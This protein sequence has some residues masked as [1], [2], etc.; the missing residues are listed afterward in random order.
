MYVIGTAGHV[1]H[2]KSTLIQAL[3]GIDPDRLPQEKERGMTIDLGFAWL[4]LPSGREVSIVDVPGHERFVK[5]MLAGVGGIDVALLVV[6]ADEGVMPQTREHLAILDLLR[7]KKGLVVITK[8][9]LVDEEMLELVSAD[10][11][12]VLQGTSFEGAPSLVV[13]AVNGRG[14]EELKASLDKMLDATEPRRDLG[15]PRLPIDR[16]F[17]VAGFGTVVTGTLVDG[18]LK[19]GQEVELA[20]ASQRCRIRGLQSHRKKL[21]EAT[22]G[23]RLAINLSGVSHQEIQ[24]GE[25]ITTPGWLKPTAIVDAHIRLIAD[26]PK[27]LKHNRG[28]TFHA[29]TAETLARVRLL[30]REDLKPCEEGW[31][32][33]HLK[34]PVPLVKGDFFVIRSA[35][36]TLGGGRVVDA[37]PRRHRRFVLPVIER[38]TFMEE[39]TGDDLVSSAVEHWGPCTLKTLA[40]RANLS[41]A[42]VASRIDPLASGGQVV[43]LGQASNPEA[44]AYPS[45]SWQELRRKAESALKSYHGQH[46]L[47]SAAP[48][49]E[50]RSRLGLS[51]QIFNRALPRLAS[52]GV[53]MEEGPGVRLPQHAVA[54]S[55]VQR[56][57]AEEYATHLRTDPFSPPTDRAIAPELLSVLVE[58]GKVVK[59]S[60]SMVFH[61]D[62]YREMVGRIVQRLREQGKITIA[63]VR[64]MFNNSRKYVMPLMDYLDQQHITRRVGDERVL[65]HDP[66]KRPI[67]D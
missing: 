26:I 11:E 8:A 50:L 59:A 6:A 19:L 61:A 5:N 4:T 14:L 22:P 33:I 62:A 23:R 34:E 53:L 25:V 64:D 18:S 67:G 41:L 21:Q 49:E 58:E 7:I 3:T 24:R 27:G 56:K 10:V 32:Q 60:D 13:S 12:D 40:Q 44:V 29:F 36:A 48:R 37:S 1:D 57:E 66:E 35:E 28:V 63:E 51:P 43:L 52:E 39:G 42:D 30:D 54:L 17:I 65:L 45:S 38:L 9:D 46:P 55:A 47:R 20:M 16:S 15:R 2:G 31:V